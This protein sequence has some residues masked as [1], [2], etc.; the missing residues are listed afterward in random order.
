MSDEHPSGADIDG[1]LHTLGITSLC[2]WDVLIFLYR[3][4]T[5]LVGADLIAR[6]LGYANGPIV[7]AL[8]VLEGLGLV[9]R[10]RVSLIAR[11]YQLSVPSDPPQRDAWAR[12]LDLA[13]N[14]AGR[15]HLSTRLRGGEPH[16]PG[17]PARGSA[18]PGRSHAVRPDDQ[19]AVPHAQRRT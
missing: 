19:A 13:S 1:W 2:Q 6:F 5:S 16:G 15:V 7:A 14:R 3:H 18:L 4:Q 11:L 10:S 9:T 17:A 12:L 8:D